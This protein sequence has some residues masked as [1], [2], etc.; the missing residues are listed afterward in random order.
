MSYVNEYMSHVVCSIFQG[1]QRDAV[2]LLVSDVHRY[3]NMAASWTQLGQFLLLNFADQYSSVINHCSQVA[4]IGDASA[5]QVHIVVF[6][7][8]YY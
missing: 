3:P 1:D 5:R 4:L 8:Y 6:I 7:D 2:A